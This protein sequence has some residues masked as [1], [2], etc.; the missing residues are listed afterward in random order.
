MNS[1]KI[2]NK[3]KSTN[4][5]R[6]INKIKELDKNSVIETGCVNVCGIGMRKPFVIH[7]DILIIADDIDE[8]IKKIQEKIK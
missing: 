7:N 1:F 3:C 6:L 5:D 4:V 2:C 8:L